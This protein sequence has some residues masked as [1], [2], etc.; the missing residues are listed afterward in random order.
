MGVR[1]RDVL[2][3]GAARFS[4]LRSSLRKVRD[5]G[6]EWDDDRRIKRCLEYVETRREFFTDERI[7]EATI[8]EVGSGMHVGLA[9]LLLACGAK[10]LINI[11]IDADYFHDEAGF[12]EKLCRRAQEDGIPVSW[13][14]RGLRLSADGSRVEP[15][16]QYFELHLGE[17]A[18]R[19]RPPAGSIDITFSV[20]V[21]EHVRTADMSTVAR[22]LFEMTKPGGVG[23]HRV[24]LADHYFRK[25]NP[26]R[27]LENSPMEYSLMYSNRGSSSNRLRMDDIERI[28]RD[29]GWEDVTYSDV[30]KFPDVEQFETFRRRFHPDFRDR[31]PE[32]L[33]ATSVMLCLRR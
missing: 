1:P 31:D 8:L 16:P 14:P 6:K 12:Y 26:F 15:D 24:D 32:M 20:A 18:A 17:N 5:R 19:V 22:S 30:V 10:K 27:F 23:Y 13:P 2:L 4:S 29:A 7:Q 9:T 25:S 28:F 11:E 3:N 33:R 21:F